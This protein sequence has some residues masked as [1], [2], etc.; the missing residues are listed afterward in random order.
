LVDKVLIWDAGLDDRIVEVFKI[1]L[2]QQI[3]KSQRGEH[4]ELFFGEI[5]HKPD[6]AVEM[7][8]VLVNE[9]GTTGLSVPFE[10]TFQS[11]EAGFCN[12]L[13]SLESEQGEWLRVD[14]EYA[15]K[16]LNAE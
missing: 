7:G 10:E 15:L 11:F 2:L 8:F 12:R 6:T 3:D 9:S 16:C 13:P 4:P 1:L 14:R 5:L